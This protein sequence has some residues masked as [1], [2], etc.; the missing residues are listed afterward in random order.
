[1]RWDGLIGA[2]AIG[3]LVAT[4]GATEQDTLP[5]PWLRTGS[6]TPAD[7]CRTS[8]TDVKAM[9]FDRALVLR[10]SGGASGF[11]TVMQQIAA[12]D[13]RGKRV[14]LS[15]QVRG[16]VVKNWAGLWMRVDGDKGAVLAFDNMKNRPLKGTFDWQGASVVLNVAP[17]AT[18]LAFGVLQDGDG[19][20]FAGQLAI[21]IVGTDV[22][23]TNT[24]HT[25]PKAP[26]NLTLKP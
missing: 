13:Y 18:T 7:K 1:M 15:A 20:T 23:T 5:A 19:A 16:D 24:I 21:E 8:V 6:A 26:A 10:C 12:D 2:C 22:A 17:E 3:L 4:V 11:V 14:R 9:R 25:V